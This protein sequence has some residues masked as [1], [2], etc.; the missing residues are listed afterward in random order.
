MPKRK[1]TKSARP[2]NGSARKKPARQTGRKLPPKG[3]RPSDDRPA[4]KPPAILADDIPERVQAEYRQLLSQ[5]LRDRE[6]TSHLAQRWKKLLSNKG[7]RDEF[8]LALAGT[9][10]RMGR[11]EL[12]IKKEALAI[13]ARVLKA[14][15]KRNAAEDDLA[16]HRRQALLSLRDILLSP[17]PAKKEIRVSKAPSSDTG[18]WP[19]GALFAYK[20]LSGRYVVFHVVACLGDKS[21]GFWPVFA[22]LDWIGNE[23]PAATQLRRLPVKSDPHSASELVWLV[24]TIKRHPSDFP[25]ARIEWLDTEREPH[26]QNIDRGFAITYW[27]EKLDEK[28]RFDFGWE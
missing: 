9:Q 5:G 20:L 19:V 12:A 8:S 27:K 15:S 25:A 6:V 17:Q 18:P 21:A 2:A 10:W 24:S 16:R 26:A 13:I 3:K 14:K 23:P 1:A 11:L 4:R 22:L 7:L 28:L